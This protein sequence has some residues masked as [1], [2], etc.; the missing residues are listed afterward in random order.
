MSDRDEL[1]PDERALKDALAQGAV[2]GT[3][4]DDVP[5]YAGT[6][7]RAVIEALHAAG[8]VIRRATPSEA[9]HAAA[10]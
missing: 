1:S 7:V 2:Y 5:A 6:D 10:G 3:T 9:D 8:F 4:R